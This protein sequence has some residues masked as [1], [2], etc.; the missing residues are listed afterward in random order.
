MGATNVCTSL[1]S[2]IN[3]SVFIILRPYLMTVETKECN[4]GMIWSEIK[5]S[6]KK[7][8]FQPWYR[9][10]RDRTLSI[11]PTMCEVLC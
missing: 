5:K 6:Q 11:V 10:Y 8:S 1:C 2:P 4:D 3:Q 7:V 9:E